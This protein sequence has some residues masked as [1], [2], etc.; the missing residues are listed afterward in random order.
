[1]LNTADSMIGHMTP[2]YLQFGWASARLDDLANW[3]AARLSAL[4][5][6]LGAFFEGGI[7]AGRAAML[8]AL[9]DHGLHRSP[10][11][12]WPES[13]MAGALGVALAGPRVYS[14]ERVMEPMQNA[15]GRRDIGPQEIDLAIS[16]FASA[17][18]V[19]NILVPAL[20][21]LLLLTTG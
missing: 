20:T 21:M 19:F 10:N 15:A 14:G 8:S 18:S 2:R 12:G 17:C 6:A 1:M 16:I 5:I 13:A 9:T 3:P 4:L 11:S 7:G